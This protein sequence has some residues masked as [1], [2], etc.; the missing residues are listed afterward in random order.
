MRHPLPGLSVLDLVPVSS[1]SSPRAAIEAACAAARTAERYGYR[2]YWLA[3]HHNST[4]L[5]CSATTLIMGAVA[6]ATETIRVGSGGIMLPNHAPLRVAEDL[7]TLSVMYPDRI[8]CGLGRAPGTDRLTADRLRRSSA[9]LPDFMRDVTELHGYLG[10]STGA[11]GETAVIGRGTG[12]QFF[13]LGSSSGGARVAAELGLPFCFA[14]HFAPDQLHDAL[15]V[16]RRN[17]N[18]GASTAQLNRPWASAAVNVMV[19][20]SV[21]ESRYQLK[22]LYQ[23]FAGVLNGER[24]PLLAPGDV[25]GPHP[26]VAAHISQALRMTAYGTA[27]DVAAQLLGWAESLGLDEVITVT[28][29]HDPAV[30]RRSLALLGDEW[31]R[32]GERGM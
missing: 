12:V 25:V 3:E 30:R 14:S 6:A 2:R 1:G 21:E 9:D 24:G 19:T 18:P 31:R 15:D 16:Y 23:A 5:A 7:G 27:P 17:F 29:A 8:D 20:D 26:I 4:A 28:Y 32:R 13:I 10:P 22:T 11:P